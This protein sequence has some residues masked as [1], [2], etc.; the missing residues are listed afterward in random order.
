[1]GKFQLHRCIG[2]TVLVASCIHQASATYMCISNL[3]FNRAASQ[4]P[5]SV[6]ANY[7]Y[8]LGFVAFNIHSWVATLYGW[9]CAREGRLIEHGAWMHR[10]GGQWLITTV[11]F[12]V[13]II[14]FVAMFGSEWGVALH[15]VF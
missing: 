12:R 8:A 7:V 15:V 11:M 9:K 5:T 2:R 14:P 4:F 13:L 3:F 1:M 6:A 10:L